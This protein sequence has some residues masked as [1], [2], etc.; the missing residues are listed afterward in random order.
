MTNRKALY[1]SIIGLA[2]T[3]ALLAACGTPEPLPETIPPTA[4]SATA[5]ATPTQAPLPTATPVPEQTPTASAL[6]KPARY[7]LFLQTW[8][9]VNDRYVYADF[10]GVDWE[11]VKEEYSV[12]VADA[13]SDEEFYELM[14]EMVDLLGGKH[15]AFVTPE[16]VA[17]ENTIYDSLQ[18][19]GGIGASL[20]ETDGELVLVQVLPD[21]PAFEAGLQPGES[22]VAIDGVRWQQFSS[23]D[24]AILA[25]VGEA[26]TDVVLTVRSVDGAEREVSIV[27]APVDLEG[28][29]VQGRVVEDTEIGLLTLNGFD[30]PRVTEIVRDTLSELLGGGTLQGLIVDVRANSGGDVDTLLNTL[31]LFV[32]GGSI[33]SRAGR[34]EAYDLLIPEGQS[35]PELEGLPIIVLI[36]PRT[37]S[38]AEAFAAAMQ[39]HERAMLVGL[40]SAGNT[41]YLSWHPLSDG[42]VLHLA[43]WVYERP[44]GSRIEGR[45]VQPDVLVDM[46]WWLYGTDDDVQLQ[47]A[48]DLLASD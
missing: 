44:D 3:V 8:M 24:Q 29:L 40:P 46:D 28:T 45:G 7:A 25:I 2:L 6:S 32:D 17:L 12:K 13:A 14:R 42:S 35:I 31:A 15:S 5:T 18:I 1:A 11:A 21:N 22:I 23:I 38:S 36:G 39:L 47:A 48:I 26:G 41:E 9:F 19:P 33:G 30:S 4:R 34:K 16:L 43:E 27:R 10:G 37:N 20:D